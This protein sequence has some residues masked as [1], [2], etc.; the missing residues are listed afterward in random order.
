ML[1]WCK[2]QANHFFRYALEKI[3]YAINRYQ[4]E[5]RRLYGVLEKQLAQSS[6]GYLVG[7]RCTIADIAHWGWIAS[8][9]WSGIEIEEFP[10]VKAWDERMEAR[11]AVARGKDVPEVH[12]IKELAKDKT[13]ADEAAAKAS[14][15]VQEGQADDAKR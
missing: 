13:K 14:K 10:Q 8:A 11:P 9:S 1:T 5:T 6:S 2:G 15:W 7:D 12:R 4:N 3:D